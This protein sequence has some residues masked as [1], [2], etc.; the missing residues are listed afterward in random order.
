MEFWTLCDGK[1]ANVAEIWIRP[2]ASRG[3]LE[4]KKIS[5]RTFERRELRALADSYHSTIMIGVMHSHR[6][7]VVNECQ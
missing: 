6:D 3:S 7:M 2:M 4:R 5:V 1:L